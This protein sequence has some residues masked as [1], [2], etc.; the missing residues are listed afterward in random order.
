MAESDVKKLCCIPLFY[1]GWG[2][3]MGVGKNNVY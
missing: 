2:S 3:A 1:V